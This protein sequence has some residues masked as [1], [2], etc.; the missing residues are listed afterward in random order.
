MPTPFCWGKL[1]PYFR[2]GDLGGVNLQRVFTEPRRIDVAGWLQGWAALPYLET[3]N[4][5]TPDSFNAF[6]MLVG[7]QAPLFAIYL[8]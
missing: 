8:N 5:L 7:G 2:I 3:G 6:D 4:V 1:L